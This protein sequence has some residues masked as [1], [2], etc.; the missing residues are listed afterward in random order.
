MDGSRKKK[1]KKQKNSCIHTSINKSLKFTIKNLTEIF[2][3]AGQN[4]GSTCP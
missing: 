4:V 3:H 1:N 2:L